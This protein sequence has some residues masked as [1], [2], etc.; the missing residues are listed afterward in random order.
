M[1]DF[2]TKEAL[3]AYL[4]ANKA[5]LLAEKKST[6]KM[7]DA[8]PFVGPSFEYSHGETT[9]KAETVAL[10]DP[11][12]PIKVTSVI[13]TTNIL[14]SHGDVHLP[15]IWKKSL[16][17]TKRLFLI[18]EHRFNFDNVISDN[19]TAT[20]KTIKWSTLGFPWEGSTQALIFES[21]I[22]PTD[23]TGM[24]ERYKDGKVHEHSVGMRYIKLDLAINNAAQG[25][26]EEKA[27]WDKYVDQIVNKEAAIDQGYFWAVTEAQVI[28]GSAVLRGSNYAT[29]TISVKN[30]EPTAVT[31]DPEPAPEPL[32]EES[33]FA[34]LAKH[35]N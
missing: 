5:I 15:G 19:V 24:F 33:I 9:T 1:K 6:V 29:P 21:E 4:K 18:K 35:I 10:T 25:Y 27:V 7:A 11:T 8:V 28:E 23:K 12:G 31:P 2:D 16:S 3:F 26:E 32:K 14:D 20:A 13:N 34:R 22:A 17:E 30:E